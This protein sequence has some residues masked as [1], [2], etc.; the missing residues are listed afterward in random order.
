MDHGTRE[1]QM[2]R[3]SLNVIL[4]LSFLGKKDFQDQNDLIVTL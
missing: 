1:K 2:F 3:C 4:S